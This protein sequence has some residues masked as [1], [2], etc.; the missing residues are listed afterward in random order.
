MKKFAL[1]SALLVSGG[2]AFGQNLNSMVRESNFSPIVQQDSIIV[3]ETP[4]II[5]N[6]YHNEEILVVVEDI[7]GNDI[8]SKIVFKNQCA[9]LK[10]EDPYNK[11]PSGV[12]TIVATSRNEIYNQK[13]VVD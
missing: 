12:Y 11:I 9:V 10:A 2:F 3:A 4:T 1:L 7:M 5:L 13:I 8:Y 6:N